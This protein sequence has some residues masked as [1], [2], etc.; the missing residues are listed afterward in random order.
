MADFRKWFFALAVVALMLGASTAYAQLPNSGSVQCNTTPSNPTIVRVEG[1]TEL[2]GDYVLNCNGGTPTPAG[3]QIP[4]FD[5][6][7]TLNANI[8]SRLLGAGYIDALLVIDEAYPATPFPAIGVAPPQQGSPRPQTVCF[9][10]TTGQGSTPVNCNV[11]NGTYNAATFTFAGSPYNQAGSSN[12]YVAHSAS[13]SQVTWLGVPI[14][15]PGTAGTRVLRMTNVRANACLVGLSSTLVPSSIVGFVS[16]NGS[17]SVVINGSGQQTLA[18]VQT[19][20]IVGGGNTPVQQCVNL[21]N[22]GGGLGGNFFAGAGVGVAVT[23]VSVTEGFAASFKRR[24]AA[25]AVVN[26]VFD[27]NNIPGPLQNVPGVNYNSETGFQ[28]PTA[29]GV[30]VFGLAN[31]GTRVLLVFNNVGTGVQIVLPQFVALT[32]AG[33]VGQGFPNPANGAALGGWSGGFLELVG[34]GTDLNGNTGVVPTATTLFN[35]LATFF[36]SPPFKGTIG[37]TAPFNAGVTVPVTGGVATAVYEVGNSDPFAVESANIPVGVGYVSNTGN[38]LP[39]VGQATVTASFAPLSTSNT[40]T[41]TDPIP[42]FCNKST[43]RNAFNINLCTC[44][45]L[46]PFVTNQSGFDT[47]IA[48]ANTSLD[49]YGTAPQTGAVTLTYFGNTTGGGAAPAAQVSATVAGGTELVFTL[50]NGGDHGIAA[51]PGFQGY[52]IAQAKFQ[53]C[54]AFAFISDLGAQKL[55]EGYLAIE[56]DLYGGSGL[57]RTGIFGEVQGH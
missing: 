16:L 15:A 34:I 21:N 56:L 26:D 5:L 41:S 27:A 35:N 33:G 22:G 30:S 36:T 44:N 17:N 11:F 29:A 12:V 42:R 37:V 51:T 20:L 3:Q 40:A 28:P 1:L 14:D 57:N 32:L 54:H 2:V 46:F 8:T 4:Q 49:V 55:A 6:T 31:Q 45:L 10:N 13:I 39:A 50:S 47:G 48:I 18:Y 19:G 25:T 53:W 43:A 52:I 23:N 38:N 24:I 9:S 7:L